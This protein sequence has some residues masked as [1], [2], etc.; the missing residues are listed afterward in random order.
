MTLLFSICSI[1]LVAYKGGHLLRIDL[2]VFRLTTV[3]GFHVECVSKDEG[4]ALIGTQISEPV[5]GEDACNGDEPL[6]IGGNGLEEGFRSGL[7]V[8]MEQ[9]VAIVAQ[10]PEIHGAGM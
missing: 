1:F 5:P 7:H 4:N 8:A 6:A 3:D 10:D 2:V 9:D